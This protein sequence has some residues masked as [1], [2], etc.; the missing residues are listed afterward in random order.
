M[1]R[2]MEGAR[3]SYKGN[4][5]R[6]S[7]VHSP[8]SEVLGQLEAAARSNGAVELEVARVVA[9]P[10]A[11]HQYQPHQPFDH[12]HGNYESG[13]DHNTSQYTASPMLEPKMHVLLVDV[14]RGLG[15]K[16]K[17]ELDSVGSNQ[18]TIRE[19]VPGTVAEQCELIV[20]D[21]LLS[22]NGHSLS[23]IVLEE[24]IE[25]LAAARGKG[26]AR[27][28]STVQVPI[29]ANAGPHGISFRDV[30]RNRCAQ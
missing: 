8:S 13:V 14:E 23:G 7:V 10:P 2:I 16:I 3:A 1:P 21:V 25:L 28:Q 18:V 29:G 15:A 12:H 9:T 4:A 24:A 30:S 20:G 22:I 6:K 11:K 26:P 5:V 19:V 27:T 17:M